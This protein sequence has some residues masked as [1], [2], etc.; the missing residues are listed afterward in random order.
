MALSVGSAEDLFGDDIL[1]F[2]DDTQTDGFFSDTET[3][4]F[5]SSLPEELFA[6]PK[7]PAH[8]QPHPSTSAFAS[9]SA[10]DLQRF[11][12][13]NRNK[14]TQHSTNTWVRR[15]QAWQNERNLPVSIATIE[16]QELDGVLQRF[17]AE[18]RKADG[19]EYEP[20]SLR[21]MLGAL[22]RHFREEGYKCRIL[23][24]RELRRHRR[25]STAMQSSCENKEKA[26][27]RNVQTPSW[28]KRKCCGR[29]EF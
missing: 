21:T 16:P 14:N 19:T 3:D 13:K 25:Y 22:Y 4:A 17:F 15:F 23:K 20:E 18:I 29:A 11:K 8:L 28:K 7:E 9:A 5:F 2:L 24:D 26:K 12:D 27:G 10:A 6:E 1:D